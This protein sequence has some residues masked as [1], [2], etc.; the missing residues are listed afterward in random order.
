M[1][2]TGLTC[3][4]STKYKIKADV[5]LDP[6]DIRNPKFYD[7]YTIEEREFAP[8]NVPLRSFWIDDRAI[9]QNDLQ[10][11]EDCFNK[12]RISKEEFDLRY[13]NKK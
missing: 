10:K 3:K 2:F 11:A 6:D 9:Y 8:K 4:K 13:K 12:E 1:F 5:E 7:E